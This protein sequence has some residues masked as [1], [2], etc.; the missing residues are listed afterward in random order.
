MEIKAKK[1]SQNV[2]PLDSLKET[3]I[4][5]VAEKLA[6]HIRPTT[7]EIAYIIS[8]VKRQQISPTAIVLRGWLFDFSPLFPKK[9]TQLSIF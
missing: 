6:L 4:Y 7:Q 9:T 8:E 2:P 1:Y 3:D 5:K